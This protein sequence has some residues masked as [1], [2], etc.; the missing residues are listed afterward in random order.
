MIIALAVLAGVFFRS[1][2]LD[3]KVFW[4]DEIYSALRVDGYT[5]AE[6]VRRA[7]EFRTAGELRALLHSPAPGTGDT[8]LATIAALASEE[9][10]HAPLFYLL[11]RSWAHLAGSS[12]FSMR[13]LA[14][15]FG[16]LELPAAYWLGLELFR[17]RRAAW[18]AVGFIAISPI[19][20]LYSQEFREY[21]LW[22]AALLA[23]S[24]IFLRAMRLNTPWA[25]AAFAMALT[26][27][28]YVDPLSSVVAF[29]Y[30][31]FYLGRNGL[32]ARAAAWPALA[33]AIAL[34]LFTPWIVL[35]AKGAHQINRAT[36]LGVGARGLVF[37]SARAFL[38]MCR[39]D[40]LD[41]NIVDGAVRNALL[42]VP[43]LIVVAYATYVTYRRTAS[44]VWGFILALMLPNLVSVLGL[45]LLSSGVRLS[46]VRLLIPLFLGI[47][48]ALVVLFEKTILSPELPPAR[49]RWWALAF[50]LIAGAKIA[51][52][53][54]SSQAT[55]W[56]N[57]LEQTSLPVAQAINRAQNPLLVDESYLVYALALSE[58]LKPGVQTALYPRCY[59]CEDALNSQTALANLNP[60]DFSDVFLVAPTR[61]L[62]AEATR[63]EAAT[64]GPQYHCIDVLHNCRSSLNL[65][66]WYGRPAQNVADR[67]Q[68]PLAIFPH[69]PREPARCNAGV[70][71]KR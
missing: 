51:Q 14:A 44:A 8:P 65:F 1:Y 43:A 53:A 52:C 10:H 63:A 68:P 48:L 2:N 58:Y 26:I 21:S 20:V 16:V 70:A 34:G 56:W 23:M 46:P 9:P 71:C 15:L 38:A 35:L 31:I 3:H 4:D 61:G 57:T 17:S 6:L 27:S 30:C 5:E 47:D 7:H 37:Q 55:T 22:T 67:T 32:H 62:I 13:A 25:W 39:S 33:F 36:E 29:G 40:F 45:Y 64:D 18:L 49:R 28:L 60:Q 50:S 59:L 54:V 66:N 41:L 19:A 24:A 12:L 42:A 11:A 69:L